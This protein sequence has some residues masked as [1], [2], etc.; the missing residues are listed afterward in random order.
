MIKSITMSG[1]TPYTSPTE[2]NLRAINYF[3]GSNGSGKSTIARFLANP[4]SLTYK[5]CT[6][7]EEKIEKTN[8]HVYNKDYVKKNFH[9]KIPSIFLLGEDFIQQ[10]NQ[11][12]RIRGEIL[13]QEGMKDQKNKTITQFKDELFLRR[14]V[15]LESFWEKSLKKLESD[16]KLSFTG[17]LNS[18]ERFFTKIMTVTDTIEEISRDDLKLNYDTAYSEQT[19]EISE[20]NRIAFDKADFKDFIEYIK[21]PIVSS[22]NS[23]ISLFFSTIGNLDWVGNGLHF[24]KDDSHICPF[25]TS[26]ISPDILKQIKDT[27]DKT[28]QQSI[29][30]IKILSIKMDVFYSQILSLHSR[31]ETSHSFYEADAIELKSNLSTLLKTLEKNKG[32][33]ERKIQNPSESLCIDDISNN[34]DNLND[35]IININQK[36]HTYNQ[37]IKTKKSAQMRV[38]EKVWMLARKMIV[39]DIKNYEKFKNGR[40]AA[41]LAIS[42]QI[43]TCD[44]KI[45]ALNSQIETIEKEAL[46]SDETLKKINELLKAL[47]FQGFSLDHGDEKGTYKIVRPCGSEAKDT[48]S[49]GEYNFLTFL[50][51]YHNLDGSLESKIDISQKIIVI[52]DPI[53]SLDS[54]ILFIVSKLIKNIILKCKNPES[55]GFKQVIILTHNIY[56]YKEVCF[57][58]NRESHK[59]DMERFFVIRKNNNQSSV[60]PYEKSPIRTNYQLLWQ[61][62]KKSIEQNNF[63]SVYN[64]MRRILEYYFNILGGLNYEKF[65]DGLNPQEEIAFQSLISWIND[66]SHFIYDDLFVDSSE[67]NVQIYLSVFE[68]IFEKSQHKAHYDMM[69][70]QS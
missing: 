58:G 7:L 45:V 36:I 2:I 14:S 4:A 33:V 17:H 51:F 15:C 19:H 30:K 21:E 40:E 64:N 28:Y 9:Q 10:K 37:T 34:V 35:K 5:N 44:Q 31:I 55:S 66:G 43:V 60:D 23:N 39:D 42:K 53:S 70:N 49:E 25:C 67:S 57:F 46:R 48:L 63:T 13:N 41:I 11:I 24:I 50:Y 69:W 27:F 38:N 59:K 1:I 52:D 29:S 6:L 16:F 32:L 61:E 62:L 8:I 54:N 26:T 47:C 20:V 65:S 18:K 3:Y 22:S 68:K 56:F 12:E